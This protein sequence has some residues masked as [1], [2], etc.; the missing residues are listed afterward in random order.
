[1]YSFY[2]VRCRLIIVSIVDASA[3]VVITK[4]ND[5]GNA[6][7]TCTVYGYMPPPYGVCYWD[8][9]DGSTQYGCHALTQGHDRDVPITN[10]TIRVN[11]TFQGYRCNAAR[12]PLDP[13]SWAATDSEKYEYVSQGGEYTEYIVAAMLVAFT[14]VVSIAIFVMAKKRGYFVRDKDED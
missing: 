7:L 12:H 5:T 3:K 6:T 8:S 2:M 14:L 4:N 13:L 10:C 1:M 9:K 11:D